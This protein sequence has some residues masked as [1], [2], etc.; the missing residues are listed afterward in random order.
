MKFI[1]CFLCFINILF[2][3]SPV[4]KIAITKN[5]IPYSFIDENNKAKGILVDYWK[6]WALK[7]SRK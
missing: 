3:S 6:L 4:I 2:A 5:M 1:F 7:H